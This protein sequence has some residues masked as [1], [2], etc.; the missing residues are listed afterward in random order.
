MNSMGVNGI[1]LGTWHIAGVNSEFTSDHL[2]VPTVFGWACRQHAMECERIVWEHPQFP[3]SIPGKSSSFATLLVPLQIIAS[4]YHS[5]SFET[6]V[7]SVYFHPCID[8]SLCRNSYPSTPGKS[9]LAA[10]EDYELFNVH[11]EMTIKWSDWWTCRPDWPR[12]DMHLI[13]IFR[14]TSRSL[15]T[16]S[17]YA[18]GRP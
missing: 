8:V 16:E 14:R 2:A 6:Q 17:G 10:G 13:I 7:F 4:T 1:S 9:G 11:L 15:L 12:L 18:V 5:L 3:T